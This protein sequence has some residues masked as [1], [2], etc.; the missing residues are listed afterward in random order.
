LRKIVK[1]L[2]AAM[3]I[4][5]VATAENG[6]IACEKLHLGQ[7]NA[8]SEFNLVFLDLEMRTF[9]G[10]TLLRKRQDNRIYDNVA[11]IVIAEQS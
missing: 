1:V 2:L 8:W 3:D 6:K 4:K 5:N 9:D 7:A 11:F 10:Y